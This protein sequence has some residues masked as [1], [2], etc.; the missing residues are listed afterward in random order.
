MHLWYLK[1][2]FSFSEEPKIIV[3]NVPIVQNNIVEN[4]DGI[5]FIG[6]GVSSGNH[7][8]SIPSFSSSSTAVFGKEIH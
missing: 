1:H 2:N 4:T 3:Y 8:I 5:S 7:S 6:F